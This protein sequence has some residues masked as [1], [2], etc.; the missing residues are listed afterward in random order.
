MLSGHENFQAD[1]PVTH[2]HT[3]EKKKTLKSVD[4]RVIGKGTLLVFVLVFCMR[5]DVVL[6]HLIF[7][8]LASQS[9][10]VVAKAN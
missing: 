2:T 8:S 10:P 6:S 3:R 9:H 7:R 1:T 5:D 4:Q